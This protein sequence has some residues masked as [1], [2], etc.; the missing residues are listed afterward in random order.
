MAGTPQQ[1]LHTV[2]PLLLLDLD[3]RLQ[4][5]QMVGIAQCVHHTVQGVAGLPVA[6]HDHAREVC[7]QAAAL[8]G[9]PMEG[10]PDVRGDVQLLRL[11]ANPEPGLVPVPDGRCGH[12][13]AN[14]GGKS[15]EAFGT[16]LADPG[17]GGRDQIHT[18]QIAPICV[19]RRCSGRILLQPLVSPS[20]R[21]S[22][23]AE[24][25]IQRSTAKSTT[26]GTR[27]SSSGQVVARIAR[28][29]QRDRTRRAAAGRPPRRRPR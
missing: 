14:C 6:V 17:D 15:L 29:Q 13:S 22:A 7:Q 2:R 25:S 12:A 3:Q 9:D 10:Q 1:V 18:V 24:P 19:A 8:R 11:A 23:S 4:F 20:R 26:W 28:H 16:I 5:A 27:R 21:I